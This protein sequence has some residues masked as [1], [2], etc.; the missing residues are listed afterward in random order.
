MPLASTS[1]D[2]RHEAV[3]VRSVRADLFEGLGTF[4]IVGPPAPLHTV[5]MLNA[6]TDRTTGGDPADVHS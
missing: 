4:P 6:T 2:I 3:L 5:Q 1:Q